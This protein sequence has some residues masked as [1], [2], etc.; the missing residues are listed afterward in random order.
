MFGKTTLHLSLFFIGLL[1]HIAS[2]FLLYVVVLWVLDT[3]SLFSL[4][5]VLSS[6]G[7]A[8]LWLTIGDFFMAMVSDAKPVPCF[9]SCA[10]TLPCHFSCPLLWYQAV[11]FLSAELLC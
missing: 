11:L 2:G 6:S 3:I 4:K 8:F 9:S 1:F 7:S 10:S 5:P